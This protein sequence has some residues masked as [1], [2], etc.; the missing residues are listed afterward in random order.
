M[1]QQTAAACVGV[2]AICFITRTHSSCSAESCHWMAA[3]QL[4]DCSSLLFLDC[5]KLGGGYA[6][7]DKGKCFFTS[8]LM[9][10]VGRVKS[11]EACCRAE[12]TFL[13]C[14]GLCLRVRLSIQSESTMTK[15]TFFSLNLWA[16]LTWVHSLGSSSAA[17]QTG[18]L[19]RSCVP[20]PMTSLLANAL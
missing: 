6:G 1:G 9:G 2:S 11:S 10:P 12:N 13:M 16:D 18:L 15:P 5:L 19:D 14:S 4:A 8:D 20:G 3:E 7:S 17:R